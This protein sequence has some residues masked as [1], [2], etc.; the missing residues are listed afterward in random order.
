MRLVIEGSRVPAALAD[1]AL[2]KVIAKGRRLPDAGEILLAEN[3]K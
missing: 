3:R 1:L 2:I